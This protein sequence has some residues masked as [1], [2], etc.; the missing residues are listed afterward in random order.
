MT[1][2][3]STGRA[4]SAWF[5]TDGFRVRLRLARGAPWSVPG[6]R[7]RVP[8]LPDRSAV[9]VPR[10]ALRAPSRRERPSDDVGGGRRDGRFA[11]ACTGRTRARMRAPLRRRPNMALRGSSITTISASGSATPSRSSAT[12]KASATVL[13]VVSTHSTST[14]ASHGAVSLQGRSLTGS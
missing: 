8:L 10:D 13:P 6:S 9:E 11:R 1:A 2:A 12:S 5:L 7:A 3:P 14:V 4:P